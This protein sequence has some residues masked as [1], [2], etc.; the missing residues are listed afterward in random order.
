MAGNPIPMKKPSALKSGRQ[1]DFATASNLAM[2]QNKHHQNPPHIAATAT[3]IAINPK[4]PMTSSHCLK[5]RL[6]RAGH[7]TPL[8]ARQK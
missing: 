5:L 7:V 4:S 6:Q 2:R 8:V 3:N 1:L